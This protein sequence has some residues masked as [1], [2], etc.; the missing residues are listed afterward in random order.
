MPILMQ[1]KDDIV[2]NKFPLEEKTVSIGR[3]TDNDIQLDDKTV[4][5]NHAWLEFLPG[6]DGQP[7]SYRLIDLKSTNGSFVNEKKITEQD[8]RHNDVL[9]IGFVSF[10]FVD[11]NE[12]RFEETSKVHKSWIPG[13]YYT[14]D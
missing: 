1:I 7:G 6:D 5:A 2:Q 14:K 13:V 10:K 4:S 11:E 12:H 9:R 8:V 3:G